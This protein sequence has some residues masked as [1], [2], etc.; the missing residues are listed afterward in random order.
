MTSGVY[1]T[2]FSSSLSAEGLLSA[3]RYHFRCMLRSYGSH[4]C[5]CLLEG[6][7]VLHPIC[8]TSLLQ[9]YL[10]YITGIYG[11]PAMQNFVLGGPLLSANAGGYVAKRSVHDW[12]YGEAA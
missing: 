9:G 2:I 1:G 8:N 10:Y 5:H 12:L 6:L 3:D 7:P 4:H 11:G